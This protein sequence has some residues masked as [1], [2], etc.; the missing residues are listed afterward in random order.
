MP[1]P[2]VAAPPLSAEKLARAE[3]TFNSALERPKEEREA[4]LKDA[5]WRRR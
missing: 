5:V 1:A 2:Q 4:F 3:A